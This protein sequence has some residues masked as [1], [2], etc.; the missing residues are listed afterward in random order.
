MSANLCEALV[1]MKPSGDQSRLEIKVSWS[2]ARHLISSDVPDAVSFPQ[3]TFAL[4]EE[5]GRQLHA[6]ATVGERPTQGGLSDSRQPCGHFSRTSPVKSRFPQTSDGQ[7]ARVKIDLGRDDYA[8]ACDAHRD[9]K[10][11]SVAGIIRH[12][13]RTREFVLSHPSDFQ[14]D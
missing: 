8:K 7:I 6:R 2:R 9:G 12:D 13:V 14:V 11:A 4:I 3:E 1:K 5:A 10:Q